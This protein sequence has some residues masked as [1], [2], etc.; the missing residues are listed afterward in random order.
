MI[1]PAPAP[2]AATTATA[3]N[4]LLSITGPLHHCRTPWVLPSPWNSSFRNTGYVSRKGP[5]RSLILNPPAL[6]LDGE[7]EAPKG[8]DLFKQLVRSRGKTEGVLVPRLVLLKLFSCG[9]GPVLEG[10]KEIVPRYPET[11]GEIQG[12]RLG[13]WLLGE[14]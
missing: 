6:F 7:T 13:L 1:A 2:N 9:L 4:T 14:I 12:P 10:R 8:N 3:K 5:Y 11:F